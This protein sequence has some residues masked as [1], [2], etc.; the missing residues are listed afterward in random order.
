MIL[1]PLKE[2]RGTRF[3]RFLIMTE[4]GSQ[5]GQVDLEDYPSKGKMSAHTFLKEEYRGKGIGREMYDELEKLVV[6]AFGREFVPSPN[7]SRDALRIWQKRDPDALTN[8]YISEHGGA[9]V[10][11]RSLYYSMGI[12]E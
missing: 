2:T 6:N 7:L 8:H 5:L 3:T 4:E 12:L 11:D 9:Y 1:Q 10:R